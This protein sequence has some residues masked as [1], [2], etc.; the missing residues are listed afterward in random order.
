[1][2]AKKNITNNYDRD[3]SSIELAELGN[4]AIAIFKKNNA[5]LFGDLLKTYKGRSVNLV[6]IGEG[7]VVVTSNGRSAKVSPGRSEE[8][9]AN[10]AIRPEALMAILDEEISPAQAFHR[11]S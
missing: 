4:K 3:R 5:E 7:Q 10:S 2:S 8:P 11:G 6:I 1:M 9:I